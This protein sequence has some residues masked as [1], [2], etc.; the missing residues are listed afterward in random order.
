MKANRDNVLV[1]TATAVRKTKIELNNPNRRIT[2]EQSADK[3]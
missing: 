2:I 1:L 3:Y